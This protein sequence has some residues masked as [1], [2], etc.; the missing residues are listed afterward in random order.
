MFGFGF[1]ALGRVD[2][3]F[4]ALQLRTQLAQALADLLDVLSRGVDGAGALGEL[5]GS[6]FGGLLRLVEAALGGLALLPRALRGAQVNR[7]TRRFAVGYGCWLWRRP[8]GRNACRGWSAEASV[9]F[10]FR[11]A[12]GAHL[13]GDFRARQSRAQRLLRL[14]LNAIGDFHANAR[15]ELNRAAKEG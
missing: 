15:G 1:R 14:A 13:V 6:G 12:P 2:V 7:L 4:G 10:G 3:G 8:R 9:A 11:Q 5:G